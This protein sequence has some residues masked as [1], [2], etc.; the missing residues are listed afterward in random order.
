MS[1][2][3][4]LASRRLGAL[5]LSAMVLA[6]PAAAQMNMQPEAHSTIPF[7]VEKYMGQWYEIARLDHPFERGLVNVTSTRTQ[8]PD[9]TIEVVNR[10][11][12]KASGEVRE[13]K[14]IARVIDEKIRPTIEIS[15]GPNQKHLYDVLAMADDGSHALIG[16]TDR[17]ALWIFARTPKLD[18]VIVEQLK[19]RALGA[20]YPVDQLTLVPQKG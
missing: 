9:G 4:R 16:S 14:A 10:G 12:D 5:V 8:R 18:P 15:Y 19:A 13:T 20:G 2:T 1:M 6:T 11:V 7:S 17:Q 3:S